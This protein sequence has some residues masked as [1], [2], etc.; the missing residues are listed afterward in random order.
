MNVLLN[1]AS[2][3]EGGSRV[4]LRA[5]LERMAAQRLDITWTVAAPGVLMTDLPG[6]PDVRHIETGGLNGAAAVLRWYQRDLALAVQACRADVMLSI[7]NYL[8][9]TPLACPSVLLVQHAGHFSEVFGKLQ[10]SHLGGAVAR[11]AWDMKSRWV[12]QSARAA[13]ILTVQTAALADEIARSTGR[14]RSAIRVVAH[15]PGAVT[16]AA[17]AGT[18]CGQATR[19]GYVSKWGVQKNFTV[20]LEAAARL[21]GEGRDVRI[22]LTLDETQADN[23]RLLDRAARMGLGDAIENHGEVDPGNVADLYAT[24]DLF[25]FAS[26]VESF[27]F[28]MVEAMAMGLPLLCA[29]T[30]C[31][32]EVAGDG[33]SFFA[34][35]DGH[36]L[37]RQ[38]AAWMDDAAEMKRAAAAAAER[39]RAFCWDRAA[40]ET[41]ALLDEAAAT[42]SRSRGAAA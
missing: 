23:R 18:R 15:G 37:A 21:R 26:L 41:L 14:P 32:R 35:H 33:G 25:V 39:G 4:V 31:N 36:D 29:D 42:G 38:I 19:I 16:P 34:A 13:T 5:L 3:R 40:R 22:V 20:V 17:A 10:R 1:A 28:P 30:P 9:L 2:I 12:R 11:L 24:L 27:G 6:R 7:T 8:P